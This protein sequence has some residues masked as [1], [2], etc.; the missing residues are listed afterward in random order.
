MTG[1]RIYWKTERGKQILIM[2]CSGL[3]N[4]QIKELIAGGYKYYENKEPNSVLSLTDLTNTYL[5]SSTYHAF[6]DLDAKTH[7]YDLKTAVVGLNKAKTILLNLVNK[8][9]KSQIKGFNSREEAL[10]WL[11]Q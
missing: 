6:K 5:T 3:N 2:D 11:A 8:F 7:E 10:A 4:D 9:R 1:D